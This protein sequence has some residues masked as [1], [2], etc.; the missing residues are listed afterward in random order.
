[1]K[2]KYGNKMKEE[3]NEMKINNVRRGNVIWKQRSEAS[4]RRSYESEMA[5]K[6]KAAEV[7]NRNNENEMA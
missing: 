2:M 4:K 6:M 5:K 3:N 1:M 7:N